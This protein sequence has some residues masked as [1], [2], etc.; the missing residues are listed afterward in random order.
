MLVKFLD[1]RNQYELIK[2][3]I[4]EQISDCINNS[5]F[6][7]GIS[8]RNFEEQF[9]T[10]QQT[11]YCISCANGTDALEIAIE[12]LNIPKNSEIIVPANSFISTA[13]AVT[14]TGNKI[15]FADIDA[16]TYNISTD[17]VSQLITPSTKVIIAVHLYGNP[18][19][20]KKLKEISEKNNLFLIEDCAQAHGSEY[21]GKRVGSF[22]DLGTFSFYP[23]KNLG[24]YGDG[25]AITTNN[26]EL[27]YRC[28]LIANH[29]R[30]EK[31]NHIIEGRNSRLDALQARI[32]GVK[33]KYLDNWIK[34]KRL[35]AEQYCSL[36]ENRKQIIL[37]KLSNNKLHSFHL[38]VIQVKERDSLK[39]FLLSN[40]IE[41]GI[42]Y[43]ISLPMLQAY[44]YLNQAE[45]T[46]VAN[47]ISSQIISL[48]IGETLTIDQIKYVCDKIHQ[49]LNS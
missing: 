47:N 39:S 48:P 32:L 46:K 41:T 21:E 1:L 4:D 35:L 31:Y 37:P 25:G 45:N 28:R 16:E 14:R 44:K 12:A 22:G 33:L 13:E 10:Y 2:T 42:H 5:D 8:V 24:A 49:F 40:G 43:P 36:L 17:H 11:K 20:I 19:N 29:G 3:E 9:A 7:G 15:V 18:S 23:G 34:A 27:E 26:H 30:V 6:V 38:F